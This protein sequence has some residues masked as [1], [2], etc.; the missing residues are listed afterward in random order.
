MVATLGIAGLLVLAQSSR[1]DE[2][3]DGAGPE[4][5]VAANVHGDGF[6][7][8]Q[9]I[10]G[11]LQGPV[12]IVTRLAVSTA[13]PPSP[14]QIEKLTVR[15]TVPSHGQAHAAGLLL[16]VGVAE[17]FSPQ[18]VADV[19]AQL[20]WSVKFTIKG[21]VAP[22]G[23]THAGALSNL[24]AAGLLVSDRPGGGCDGAL[25]FFQAAA[26]QLGLP[27]SCGAPGPNNN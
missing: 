18:Q 14:P 5:V 4:F 6:E 23:A 21:Q 1:A 24:I 22:I 7:V 15:V 3:D 20:N 25:A 8:K 17:G 10:I 11:D 13:F 12:T 2:V 9:R 26:H 27:A 16:A 19:F